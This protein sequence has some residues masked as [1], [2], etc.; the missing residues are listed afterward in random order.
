MTVIDHEY[1]R[2]AGFALA[3]SESLTHSKFWS[4][5][6]VMAILAVA[7]GAVVGLAAN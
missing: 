2:R 4:L 7:M 5:Y 3:L 1:A 6:A